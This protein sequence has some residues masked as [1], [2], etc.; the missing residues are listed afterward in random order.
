MGV[1]EWCRQEM[2]AVP[3]CLAT[4]LT[5]E[6]TAYAQV[7]YGEEQPHMPFPQRCPDCNVELAGI[8]HPHCDIQ[9][10][11]ICHEQ[12]GVCDHFAGIKI[13]GR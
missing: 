7:R 11:P 12:L 3:S 13:A 8:H 4:P 10:C 1:C 6:G 2:L 5:L 9:Q